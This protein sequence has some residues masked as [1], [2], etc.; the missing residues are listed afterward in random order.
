MAN[1]SLNFISR[2]N[3]FNYFFSTIII[4]RKTSN[5]N[6]IILE[7]DIMIRVFIKFCNQIILILCNQYGPRFTK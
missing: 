2:I 7:N 1:N 4:I 6:F 5:D 3:K